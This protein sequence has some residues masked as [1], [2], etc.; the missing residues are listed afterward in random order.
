MGGGEGECKRFLGHFRV[1]PSLCFKA[2]LSA[3]MKTSYS[4]ANKTRF[5]KKGFAL[6]LVL[7]VRVF[8]TRKWAIPSVLARK[9]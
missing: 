4:R 3:T 6:N 1:V 5:H 7:K 8:G 2:R 9:K